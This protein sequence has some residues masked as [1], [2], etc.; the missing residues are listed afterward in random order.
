[1]QTFAGRVA[2][3]TGAADGKIRIWNV[4]NGDCIR[5]I[6]SNSLCDPVLSMSI[7]DNK[8]LV[9]TENNIV[10]MEFE[11]IRYEYETSRH[12][13]LPLPPSSVAA[14]ATTLTAMSDSSADSRHRHHHHQRTHTRTAPPTTPTAPTARAAR[15]SGKNYASIRAS[16]M[17][18]VSTPNPKLF[19][20]G[21]KSALEHSAR[22]ISAKN[23]KDA[24]IVHEFTTRRPVTIVRNSIGNVSE[25]ALRKHHTLVENIKHNIH[26]RQ[27]SSTHQHTSAMHLAAANAAA[28]AAAQHASDLDSSYC[29]T[30]NYLGNRANA[31]R[32]ATT[33]TNAT[34]T[35]ASGDEIRLSN[36]VGSVV[37]ELLDAATTG[38]RKEVRIG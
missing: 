38:S 10:L 6:R 17:E 34:S 25:S 18:L 23:L 31:Y 5:V 2:A 33:T 13:A 30:E 12:A 4:M 14:T 16:R 24:H 9:N 3:I 22:P 36:E 37:Y 27:L 7:V 1:M 20:D 26:T 19:E 15:R 35:T 8:I 11:R 32:A 29:Y 21:R 28:A